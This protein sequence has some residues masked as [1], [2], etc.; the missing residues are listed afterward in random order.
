MKTMSATCHLTGLRHWQSANW[1][2]AIG[3]PASAMTSRCGSGYN[4][5]AWSCCLHRQWLVCV[6]MRQ[7]IRKVC[8]HL[9]WTR[10]HMVCS[11]ISA[12]CAFALNSNPPHA[13]SVSWLVRCMALT[14]RQ[15]WPPVA[16]VP[17]AIAVAA[18]ATAAGRT[19][20]AS[21]RLWSCTN[22]TI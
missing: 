9:M 13:G 2:V 16:K 18:S 1:A 12:C 10:D 19:P 15:A 14:S 4:A 20:L 8:L 11:C 22:C 3:P 6:S 5:S 17:G 7:Q 21:C